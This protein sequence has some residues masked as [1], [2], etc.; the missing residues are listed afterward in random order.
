MEEDD[1]SPE[2]AAELKKDKIKRDEMVMEMAKK[3]I[4]T[5]DENGH[6]SGWDEFML[7][8]AIDGLEREM[9]ELR[10]AMTDYRYASIYGDKSDMRSY[11]GTVWREGIDVANWIMFTLQAVK[12]EQSIKRNEGRK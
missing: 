11:M 1:V 4:A 6:K 7:L 5:L 10:E 2:R 9:N 3:M 8:G 12:N